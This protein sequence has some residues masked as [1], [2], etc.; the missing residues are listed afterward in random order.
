MTKMIV[1]RSCGTVIEKNCAHA[2][3]AVDMAAS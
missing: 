1:G 2:S 3:G